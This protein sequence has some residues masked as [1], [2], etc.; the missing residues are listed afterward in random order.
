MGQIVTMGEVRSPIAREGR[1][2]ID[3]AINEGCGKGYKDF[4]IVL[5][6][7]PDPFQSELIGAHVIFSKA[8]ILTPRKY[9]QLRKGGPAF[10]GWLGSLCVHIVRGDIV[11]VI[12]RP[13]DLPTDGIEMSEDTNENISQTAKNLGSPLAY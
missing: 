1:A 2:L 3:R 6:A 13:R 8:L 11:K 4:W 10:E 12:T 9:K 5:Q 7:K